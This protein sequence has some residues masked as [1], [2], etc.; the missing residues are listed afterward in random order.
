MSYFFDRFNARSEYSLKLFQ[1]CSIPA[2]M[3]FAS[4]VQ[5]APAFS[6]F[7]ISASPT[8]SVLTIGNPEQSASRAALG[9]LS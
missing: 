7:T 8:A 1:H 4:L 2:A 6:I 3:L 5:I 9:K